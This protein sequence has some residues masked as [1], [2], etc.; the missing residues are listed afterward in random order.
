MQASKNLPAILFLFFIQ[1]LQNAQQW[2]VKE[3]P[4]ATPQSQSMNADSLKAFDD[5]IA[6]GK[7]GYVDGMIVTR[8]G[9][10]LYQKS[11]EHDYDK[12]YGDSARKKSGLNA[13]DPGGPYNY[14]NLC[15]I[16]TIIEA[17]CTVCSQLQ[18]RSLR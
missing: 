11:Y 18:K 6:S 10:L 17:T 4:V 16:H 13:L 7:Y 3:W 2:P 9:K 5:A 14:Y 1:P 8:H 15:G 12:I